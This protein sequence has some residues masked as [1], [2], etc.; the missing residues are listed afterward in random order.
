MILRFETADGCVFP[1]LASITPESA[2]AAP[3]AGAIP[4]QEAVPDRVGCAAKGKIH[5]IFRA[6]ERLPRAPADVQIFLLEGR[7]ALPYERRRRSV[8]SFAH[9]TDLAVKLALSQSEAGCERRFNEALKPVIT[10]V[11]GGV[12]PY[13]GIEGIAEA[14]RTPGR[15]KIEGPLQLLR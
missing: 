1:S 9:A 7:G 2:A 13:I 15:V 5:E 4:H 12:G 11:A 8:S 10:E 3:F 14:E 6:T